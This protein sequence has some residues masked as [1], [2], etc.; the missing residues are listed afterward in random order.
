MLVSSRRLWK[1]RYHAFAAPL[2]HA[3]RQLLPS[4]RSTISYS[5][6]IEDFGLFFHDVEMLGSEDLDTIT[7]CF[8]R[9][10][11]DAARIASIHVCYSIWSRLALTEFV[12]YLLR[13]AEAACVAALDS[14][15]CHSTM[16]LFLVMCCVEVS[17]VISNQLATQSYCQEIC[18]TLHLLLPVLVEC[19]AGQ[20]V[21]CWKGILWWGI[22]R[23]LQYD[24]THLLNMLCSKCV[25][26]CWKLL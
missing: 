20:Q 5:G 22:N 6:L 1:Y 12:Q 17:S 24:A 18:F 15:Q 26:S 25:T 21:I 2:I 14:N 7:S 4:P 11:A 23:R 16:S 13:M 10:I 8:E 19:V 3:V 9:Q